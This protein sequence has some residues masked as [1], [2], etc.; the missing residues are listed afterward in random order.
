[1]H[2]VAALALLPTVGNSL[3]GAASDETHR[4]AAMLTFLVTLSGV[5]VGKIGSPFWGA[6]A[7]VAALVI[8]S[9][10]LG[11]RLRGMLP[12]NGGRT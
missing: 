11:R 6:A 2:I 4:D 8:S 10:S 7:G 1:M 3:A 9:P 12:R 5:T